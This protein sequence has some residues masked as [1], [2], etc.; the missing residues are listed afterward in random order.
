MDILVSILRLVGLFIEVF[1]VF[2][3][4]LFMIGATMET[5]FATIGLIMGI[6]GLIYAIVKR[7]QDIIDRYFYYLIGLITAY[8]IAFFL[9]R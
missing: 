4:M 3:T 8:A 6:G 1:I 9:S 7:E 2:L 5:P